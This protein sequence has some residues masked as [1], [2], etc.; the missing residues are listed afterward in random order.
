EQ[1]RELLVELDQ[2][3]T[4]M[5]LLCV[6]LGLRISEALALRWIDVD[7]LGSKLSV[8]RG[9]VQQHVDDCKTD[10]SAKTLVLAS[11]LLDALK[12]W[13]QST[14][15][16]APEDWVFASP[17]SIGRLPYSYTGVRQQLQRAAQAATIGH[18]ST[19]AFRH[20]YRSWLDAVGTSLAVQQKMMRHTD[21]RT[22]MNVYGDVVTDEMSTASMKVAE[23]A[24][25]GSTNST[26][27][28]RG[29]S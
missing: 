12:A 26:Q 21:I 4:T 22:T 24:L 14:Q 19:H 17:Y 2:P 18:L 20:S 16:S 29:S 9:I 1:F 6:C 27:A 5:T 3:F 25:R 10:G 13:K 11:D 15:F 7:W 8:R 28:A 23:L